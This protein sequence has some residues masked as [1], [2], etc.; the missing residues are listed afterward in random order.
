MHIKKRHP[1]VVKSR[2]LSLLLQWQAIKGLLLVKRRSEIRWHTHSSSL[3]SLSHS[4][5][6]TPRERRGRGHCARSQAESGKDNI[7]MG[8]DKDDVTVKR[9]WWNDAP[10]YIKGARK[11]SDKRWTPWRCVHF[12]KESEK[13]GWPAG[14]NEEKPE[15]ARQLDE[16]ASA[17]KKSPRT[18][19]FS[20]YF[21]GG[22]IFH[23]TPLLRQENA[24]RGT[25]AHPS[26]NS[27]S[28]AAFPLIWHTLWM[29]AIRLWTT[30]E[31]WSV[32]QIVIF[33]LGFNEKTLTVIKSSYT[34][35]NFILR[36]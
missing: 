26:S 29:H 28:N 17:D 36:T 21:V 25:L 34:K 22:Q 6:H 27:T 35:M 9:S 5:T 8:S 13:G 3:S 31:K 33:Q 32:L 30:V 18:R 11:M 24:I 14:R 16:R 23:A 7:V 15:S 20:D 1:Q 10:W 19:N 2:L 4:L 12:A